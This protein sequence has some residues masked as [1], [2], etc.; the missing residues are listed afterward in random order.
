MGHGLLSITCTGQSRASMW[1]YSIVPMPFLCMQTDN[2]KCYL[3][4][5]DSAKEKNYE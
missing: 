3:R 1:W 2:I 4:E 5:L